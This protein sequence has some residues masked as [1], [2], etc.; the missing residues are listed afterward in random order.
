MELTEFDK[1]MSA[2][3][4][5]EAGEHQTAR[6]MLGGGRSA[7]K[8]KA[9]EPAKAKKPYLQT[10]VYGAISLSA[11]IVLFSNEKLVTETFTRGGWYATYPVMAA[12]LFSFVHG[13][14]GSS[15]LSVLGLEAKKK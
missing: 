7:Q 12:L 8:M 3:A 5:A 2:V 6:E 1:H 13:A 11:Y 15:L 14:F 10:A 4:F 9:P